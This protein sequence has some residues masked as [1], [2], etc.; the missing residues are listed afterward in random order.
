MHLAAKKPH[1]A[2]IMDGNG[3]WATARGQPRFRGHHAGAEAVERTVAAAV[4]AK[5]GTLTLYAFSTENWRRPTLEVRALLALL[6]VFLRRKRKNL[7]KYGVRL[8]GLGRRD[9]LPTETVK[10]LA[11]VEAETAACTCLNLVLAVDYGGRWELA[12]AAQ[13]FSTLPSS[14]RALALKDGKM[15]TTFAACLPGAWLPE[16]DLLIRTAG[17]QRLSNF[18]PWHTAYAEL[19][20]TEVYWPDF[21]EGELRRA[22]AWY[23]GRERRFG[24]LSCAQ[25]L[26]TLV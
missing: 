8:R 13:K 12:A 3:R 4:A 5:L 11:E 17:E 19:Y 20:F 7:S 18:L 26:R 6:N 10:M 14:E 24:G 2:I 16:V 23:A 1:V 9:R 21:G 15:E 22:L 25:K